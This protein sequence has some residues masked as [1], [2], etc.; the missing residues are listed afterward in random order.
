MVLTHPQADHMTGLLDVLD[1]YDVKQVMAGPGVQASAGYDAWKQ[2]VQDEGAPLAIARQGMSIDLGDGA[3]LDVLGP[4]CD[5]GD[6]RRAQQHRRSAARQ[7]GQRQ[8]SADGGHRSEGGAA[9]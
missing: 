6:G 5:G 2:A 8:L 3:R 9:R 4:G 7:L 1:R